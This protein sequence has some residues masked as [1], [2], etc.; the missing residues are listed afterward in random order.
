MSAGRASV[1]IVIAVAAALTVLYRIRNPERVE[2]DDAARQRAPGKFVTLA[3]GRTHYQVAGPDSGQ[4]V[5]LV[6]GFSVP[7]YIWDS[8]TAALTAAGF[9]V[10]R[11]D[12]YGRGYSDRPDVAYN[13]DLF[14]R[15]LQQLLDSLGWR[16]PVDMI[17]LSFGGLVT[18]NFIGRHPGRV[19]SLALIDP[20]AGPRDPVPGM[21]QIRGAGPALW[22]MMA[23]PDMAEGQLSDFVEPAKWPDWPAQYREQ[24]Q[25]R[26]FGNA[27]LSTLQ[28]AQHVVLD[29]LYARVGASGT[30]TLLIWGKED[31]T[32]PI[33]RAESVRRAIPAASYHP[34]D[35]AGHLPH[36]EQPGVVNPLLI[37]FLRSQVKPES[38][39]DS[40]SSR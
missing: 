32:V 6:H 10:A 40:S 35:A 37:D 9:R 38:L 13:P 17:G 25:Y 34:I 36:M 14:D 8:T 23:L 29:S 5:M 18:A 2:L 39:S 26:G 16:D 33:E 19:R 21:F 3:D 7:S 12:T 1:L 28:E 30:P 15:Q 11:Y 24:M 4:R 27:L 31:Q 22:R 20:V